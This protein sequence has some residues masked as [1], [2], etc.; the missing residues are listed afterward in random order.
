MQL[1]AKDL[2]YKAGDDRDEREEEAQWV[3]QELH[4][5]KRQREKLLKTLSHMKNKPT[6]GSGD[7]QNEYFLSLQRSL[8]EKHNLLN[9]IRYQNSELESR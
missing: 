6:K 2:R 7:L 8:E 4:Q 9:Q 1:S 3:Q 5:A